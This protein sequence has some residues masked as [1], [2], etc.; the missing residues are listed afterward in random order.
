M[1]LSLQER[2]TNMAGYIG[3]KASVVS[4]GAEHKKV[5]DITTTTTSLTGLVYTPTL[6]HVF[7]NGVRLVDGTDYTATSGTT[8]TLTVAAEN[9]DQVVVISYATFQTSDTVSAS[10]GGTF[11][12]NVSVTGAFTSLGIDDNAT[13]TAITLDA[14]GNLL[15][16]TTSGSSPI[17]MQTRSGEYYQTGFQLNSTNADFSGALL[18][19]RAT[20]G[21][22]NTA[23]GRFLRFYSDNGS[24]ERFHV[25]GSG[26]IY[27][28][29]GI[30]LGG[31]GAANKL[32]DYEEGT[33]VPALAYSTAGTASFGYSAQTGH[34]VKVGDIVHFQ[35]NVRL[36]AFTKGTGS[37]TPL[38]TGLPFTAYNTGGYA[39]AGLSIRLYGWT[40][41][42]IPVAAVTDNATYVSVVTMSSNS[43]L[44]DI[45]DPGSGSMIWLTGT[46]RAA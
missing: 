29:S 28:A 16:G 12:G 36:N 22:V 8:I 14:S 4:S 5:F 1:Q 7:H 43:A 45:S 25:K 23:N 17:T 44:Y 3:S 40:F 2:H 42:N 39:S 27:T 26:E 31:T 24:T 32:D 37:G 19:M 38:V 41:N 6:V 9:G 33:F 10:A 13:S 15:V 21:S 30:L 35:L 20:S 46:Y 34:Y 18:D 11:A